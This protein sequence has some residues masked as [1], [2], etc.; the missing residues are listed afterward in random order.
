MIIFPKALNLTS[1]A[2]THPRHDLGVDV[3]HDGVPGLRLD[4]RLWGQELAQVPGLDAG[5]DAALR[6][7]LHVLTHVLHHGL[8]VLAEL[9]RVH[10]GQCEG[11]A[12]LRTTDF[13]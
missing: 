8:A 13:T 6:Q 2:V 7:T 3:R 4:G 5:R 9:L 1:R 10:A 12:H 11:A